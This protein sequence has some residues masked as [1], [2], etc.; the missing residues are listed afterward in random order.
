MPTPTEHITQI[1]FRLPV[2]L[3]T[4]LAVACAS[5]RCS[6]QQALH[7][8]IQLWLVTPRKRAAK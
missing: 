8:A 3:A 2:S 6:Q 5:E 7:E 1:A 4:K